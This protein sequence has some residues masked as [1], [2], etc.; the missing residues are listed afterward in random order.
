LHCTCSGEQASFHWLLSRAGP[1]ADHS[2]TAAIFLR[3]GRGA[4]SPT[5]K[6]KLEIDV[7]PPGANGVTTELHVYPAEG[8]LLQ[9]PEH[10]LDLR[11]RLPAWFDRYLKQ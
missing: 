9:K 4:R 1:A 11:Q 2:P 8:H 10:V 3:F 5:L 6:V 7:N